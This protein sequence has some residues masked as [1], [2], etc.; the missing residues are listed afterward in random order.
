MKVGIIL[1]SVRTERQAPHIVEWVLQH[2]SNYNDIVPIVLDLKD[3][4]LPFFGDIENNDKADPWRIEVKSCDSFIFIAPEFNHSISGA[5]KNALDL[6]D[7]ELHHKPAAFIGYGLSANGGRAIEHLKSICDSYSMMKVAPNILISVL[8]DVRD[9]VFQPRAWHLDMLELMIKES[10]ILY[11]YS[12]DYLDS[13]MERIGH[14]V[15]LIN[16]NK[17]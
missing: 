1:G 11:P 14:R 15:N 6:L 9:G 10:L 12:K 8:E 7:W 5:L 2:L 13:Y 4:N 3:Y 16:Y 17:E